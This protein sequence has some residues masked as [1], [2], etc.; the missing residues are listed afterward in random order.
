MEEIPERK[1]RGKHTRKACILCPSV[2]Y[3]T[4]DM[5]PIDKQSEEYVCLA[6]EKEGVV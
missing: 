6:H 3:V 4:F 1:D 5:F 2:T